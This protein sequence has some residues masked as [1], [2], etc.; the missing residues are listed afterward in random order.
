MSDGIEKTPAA[1]PPPKASANLRWLSRAVRV[2][3]VVAIL[4]GGGGAAW[5]W[6]THKPKA[7]RKPP[8]PQARL[9][10]VHTA[11]VGRE[12]VVVRAMGSVA[13]AQSIQLAPRVGGEIVAMSPEFVPG[14]LF[15]A[16]D[17][18]CRIDPEDYDLALERAKA[19]AQRQAGLAAQAKATVSQRQTDV[20][21]AQ[22]QLDIEMGQ[23]SVARR[24]YE[25]LGETEG[26]REALVLREPQLKAAHAAVEAARA[27]LEAAQASRDAARAAHETANVAVDRAELDLA[28]T[29]V[30]AP[31]NAV[32]QS[33]EVNLGS[34]VQAGTPMATLIGTDAYW[35]EASVPVDELRWIRF[36]GQAGEAGSPVRIFDEAAWGPKTSRTGKVIRL[37]SALETEGR[38]ARVLVSVPDPLVQED[39]SGETPPMLLGS[40]VRVGI[41]GSALDDVIAL[42][43]TLLREGNQVWLM[44]EAGQLAIRTVGIAYR[45]RDRVLISGGLADGDKVVTTNLMAPVAGMPLRTASA[46]AAP[47]AGPGPDDAE[48]AADEPPGK[49]VSAR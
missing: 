6:L 40:Y 38:M 19:E 20:T 21:Q 33:R 5:Y 2:L 26:A 25:L 18:I 23:Q 49:E 47:G 39:A 28:R 13:P 43:R 30:R 48:A 35:V 9:V 34:Q 3:L 36:P 16:G 44:D 41:E 24:E 42:D 12:T 45:G 17:V 7:R 27:A 46:D 37:E 31:F 32:V 8:A 29:T 22:S 10:E 15:R 4:A 11:E 14:G 1:A